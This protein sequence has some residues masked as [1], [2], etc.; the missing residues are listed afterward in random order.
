MKRTIV[1]R[2]SF[3]CC[4]L[5]TSSS[6]SSAATEEDE[7]H[8]IRELAG[9][10]G[11]LIVHV[12]AGDGRL[13]AALSQAERVVVHGLDT[14]DEKIV[15]ARQELRRRGLGS[16]ATVARW[17]PP[18]L[19]Y[20]DGLVNLMVVEDARQLSTQEILRVLAPRGTALLREA[21]GWQRIDR[22]WPTEIDE[23]THWL[24]GP[25]GNAVARD[26]LV[27]PPR[28][29]QWIAGP[30]WSRHHNTV[31]S[32]TAQVSAQG[33][34]FYIVDDAPASMHGSAPD[35]WSLVARDAFNGL[36]LWQ[37][38]IADWGW[39]AWSADWTSRFTVPTHIPA[40]LVASGDKLYATLGFNAPLTELDA[41]TGKVLR[42]FEGSDFTDE[43]L[44]E[45][46]RLIVALNS[47][48]QKPGPADE[49]SGEQE[50]LPPV[51]KSV[52]TFDAVSGKL[53]WKTGEF[54][55]LQ[56][57][58]GSMD[59]INHLSMVAGDGQIFFADREQLVSLSGE[60]G[61]ELWR[62]ERPKVPENKMRY[63]IRITDMCALV[64]HGGRLFFAQLDPDR[65][66]D[67]REI[68]GRL[69]ALDAR[70][71]RALWDHSCASWGWGHPPDVLV[72]E[73]AVWVGDYQDGDRQD[74]RPST[75]EALRKQG[76]WGR[77]FRSAFYVGLDPETGETK[78]KVSVFDAFNN[79]HHH[80]CY[81]NKATE[82]FL[83]TSY[84]GFELIDWQTGE[85]SLNHWVRATCRLGGFPCNG[86]LYANPHPCEC[87]IDSKLNGML[88]LSA[89]EAQPSVPSLA[90]R[91]V[92][93]PAYDDPQ[94]E[95]ADQQERNAWP[96]FRGDVQ[97][98]GTTDQ[99]VDP[100]SGK[101]WEASLECPLAGCTTGEGLVFASSPELPQVTALNAQNG[102]VAWHAG[103]GSGV[104]TPP[105]YHRGRL[106]FGCAD[107][108]LYC[109]R[110]A[111]GVEVWRYRAAP[112]E[113]LIGA[114][115]RLESA[116]PVH[117]SVLVRNGLVYAAAGRSSFLDGG[118]FAWVLDAASGRVVDEKAVV[119][120]HDMQVGTGKWG[121]E[122]TGAL[123][124]LLVS[125][126]DEQF[127][128]MRHHGL[129]ELPRALQG[130][131]AKPIAEP[132]VL[133]A[134]GGLRDDSFFSRIRWLLGNTPFGDYLVFDDQR[135]Y[136]VRARKDRST[137]GGFFVPGQAGYELFA[138][139]RDGSG[140]K[141][142]APDAWSIH[143]PV[144]VVAM[145][146]TGNVLFVAGTP[147]IL[148]SD[149]P[150]V[151]YEG[152]RGGTLLAVEVASGR[153]IRTTELGAA[154]SYDGM[155]SSSGRLYI[156]TRDGRLLCFGR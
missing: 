108:W 28:R 103:V 122:V 14:T 27:G 83:L 131:A 107:G 120:P 136:G 117:G 62:V 138:A 67:W 82:R 48:P 64:Y 125:D 81:R 145:V 21:S 11:G 55:G 50:S 80:R 65:P 114:F 116:W 100:A 98:S 137:D 31:P 79:G 96:I 74:T 56:S 4:L 19:P 119:F 36:L 10:R 40:R 89:I 87:Y 2:W 63:N 123:N 53:L 111:D 8:A 5:L 33:R 99:P 54:I 150:W 44:Y 9:F 18:S 39:K 93:G 91:L 154:P 17:A 156:A 30:L 46:G 66:I 126:R 26:E 57:K 75:T 95:D 146:K 84:R 16:R 22:P 23:W 139:Q 148:E 35:R 121:V 70:T 102:E 71:G 38:P 106:Y 12:G 127:V 68:R 124:D 140:S 152:R 47:K 86:L 110:A 133:R 20:A 61:R 52:A 34:M 15:Q 43:I 144:R 101:L 153:I 78:R 113:R 134:M 143:V 42:T 13:T 115:G 94:T 29:L 104:D 135:V 142:A 129:F 41:A 45:N 109:L 73:G 76:S 118:I 130:V 25:D 90:E 85:T 32:V 88:A 97:R 6:L 149:D 60:D 92:T 128:F 112:A 24:H 58:T 132:T 147:D 37:R 7:A 105:T 1:L 51:R 49:K 3:A 151:A 69:H 72:R 155:S 141:K 59:R 77:D